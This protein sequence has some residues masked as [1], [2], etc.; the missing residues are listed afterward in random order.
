LLGYQLRSRLNQRVAFVYEESSL[1]VQLLDLLTQEVVDLLL[2]GE[3]LLLRAID[4]GRTSCSF[5]ES[6]KA[7]MAG[8]ADAAR[9]SRRD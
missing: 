8:L 6:N 2:A 1:V 9:V 3:G 7:L 5:P 4:L